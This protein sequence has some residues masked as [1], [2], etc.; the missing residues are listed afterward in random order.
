VEE[1]C[2]KVS[3][4]PGPPYPGLMRSLLGSTQDQ[5]TDTSEENQTKKVIQKT[6][7]ISRVCVE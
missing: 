6:K 1:F 2:I 4:I 3:S 5:M 7:N